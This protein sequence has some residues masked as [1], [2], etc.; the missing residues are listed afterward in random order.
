MGTVRHLFGTACLIA[1]GALL[2]ASVHAEEPKHGG[3]LKIYHRDSPAS[4]SIHEEATFSTNI[5]FMGLFNNLVIY[6]Q[7]KPQNSVDTIV[8]E[9]AESWS[10][11][12]D[13]TKLIFKLRSG[14][15]WHDGKPFTAAD[16][17]CT[18]DLLMEKS[19]DKFRKNPRQ[20]WYNNVLDVT[21]N[22]DS[23]AT[24]NLKRPQPSLIALLASGYSPIYPCHVAT[25][26]M[27]V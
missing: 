14:V 13:Q 5:P 6:D 4:A 12:E 21:T 1:V 9:L 24:F 22:G 11:S 3:I 15:K 18:F 25:R 2:A 26:D 19:K 27:R 7:H 8:P 20:A 16:V 10:L 17:K 23:E